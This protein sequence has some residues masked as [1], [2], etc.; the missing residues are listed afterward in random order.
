MTFWYSLWSFGI[1]VPVLVYLDQE[2][3]GDPVGNYVP[4][5]IQIIDRQN[6]DPPAEAGAP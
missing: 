1:F 3:S 4:K 5:Y 6:V 2:K